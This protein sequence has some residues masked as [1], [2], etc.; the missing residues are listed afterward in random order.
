MLLWPSGVNGLGVMWQINRCS[1]KASLMCPP[2]G[3]LG[4]YL[5]QLGLQ[6]R[7]LSQSIVDGLQEA[8][9]HHVKGLEA[10]RGQG[11]VSGQR[12]VQN[13]LPPGAATPD[14]SEELYEVQAT[15]VGAPHVHCRVRGWG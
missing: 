6:A 14:Y 9:L 2:R 1:Y 10:Q 4:K 12:P 11:Q 7:L 3:R 13:T 15:M 8:P 5:W